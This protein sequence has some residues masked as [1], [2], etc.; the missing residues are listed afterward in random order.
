MCNI[1]LHADS[2]YR[3]VLSHRLLRYL[4]LWTSPIFCTGIPSSARL[5]VQYLM[6]P[7]L[8]AHKIRYHCRWI[9]LFNTPFTYSRKILHGLLA[10][11]RTKQKKITHEKKERYASC[12]FLK[13]KLN[14]STII[15][16]YPWADPL[17]HPGQK[18]ECQPPTREHT[19]LVNRRNR[20]TSIV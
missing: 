7:H 14:F 15:R 17:T 18:T 19:L 12:G 4:N 3:S 11:T 10:A 6:N 8:N 9:W 13:E 1:A 5:H 16:G 2:V 20:K